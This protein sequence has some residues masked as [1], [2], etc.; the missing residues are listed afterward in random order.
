MRRSWRPSSTRALK[1]NP[2]DPTAIQ[3]TAF[4]VDDLRFA[5]DGDGTRL[6]VA[7]AHYNGGG[8]LWTVSLYFDK[9]SEPRY[10]IMFLIASIL[11]LRDPRPAARSRG[12]EAQGIPHRRERSRLVR[13]GL[14]RTTQT[15]IAESTTPLLDQG[16]VQFILFGVM[17]LAILAALWITIAK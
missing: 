7:Q 4:T 13:P 15:M 9:G 12:E 14:G 11:H 2:D 6:A 3:T 10:S 1:I 8:P 17:I 16:S 5:T